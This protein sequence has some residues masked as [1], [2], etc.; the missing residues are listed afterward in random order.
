MP[1]FKNH[2][3]FPGVPRVPQFVSQP[4][5]QTEAIPIFEE[6]NQTL[7]GQTLDGAGSALGNCTVYLMRSSFLPEA[8]QPLQDDVKGRARVTAPPTPTYVAM[9][10]SDGSGNFSFANLSRNSG[11]YFLVAINAAGTVVGTTLNTLAV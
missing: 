1:A 9:T 6:S 11:P 4:Q 8:P 3:G 10:V 2:N 5:R 7:R